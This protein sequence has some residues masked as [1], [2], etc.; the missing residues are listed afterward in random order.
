MSSSLFRK[1]SIAQIQEDAAAGFATPHEAW[2]ARRVEHHDA[3]RGVIERR[4]ALEL[5]DGQYGPPSPGRLASA[6]HRRVPR[7]VIRIGL[8]DRIKSLAERRGR[9]SAITD[10]ERMRFWQS[11]TFNDVWRRATQRFRFYREWKARHAL[12][13]RVNDITEVNRFGL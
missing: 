4:I 1:K 7:L 13:D 6:V 3:C 10:P 2:A 11:A 5:V 12:P 9:Y 8:R